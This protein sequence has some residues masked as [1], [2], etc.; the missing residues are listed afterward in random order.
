MY[1]KLQMLTSDII[2]PYFYRNKYLNLA[3][4]M[5]IQLPNATGRELF[6]EFLRVVKPSF[7]VF[8]SLWGI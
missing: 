3:I 2:Q 5:H 4:F 8:E 1:K 6:T 7:L